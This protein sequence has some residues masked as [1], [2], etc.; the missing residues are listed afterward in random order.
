MK[1]ALFSTL[2][3]ETYRIPLYNM[4]ELVYKMGV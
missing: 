1:V 4:N 3:L 2:A